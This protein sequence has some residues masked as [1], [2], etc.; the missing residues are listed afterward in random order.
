MWN[1]WLD[2]QKQPM[3]WGT[4]ASTQIAL[5]FLEMGGT[6]P[7]KMGGE[8]GMSWTAMQ[9]SWFTDHTHIIY[10]TLF[11]FPNTCQPLFSNIYLCEGALIKLY[12]ELLYCLY[13]FGLCE[14]KRP[15]WGDR[16]NGLCQGSRVREFAEYCPH[17]WNGS[18]A[19][20]YLTG[21]ADYSQSG[22][23]CS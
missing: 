19:F 21:L 11:I 13:V 7:L 17:V 22:E 18:R 14:C 1:K 16:E 2:W 6:R 8:A 23:H 5:R 20:L 4:V 3:C 12:Q 9:M 10:S 15:L